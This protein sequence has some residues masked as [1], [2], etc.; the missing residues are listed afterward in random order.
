MSEIDALLKE[1]RRFPPN[2]QWRRTAQVT[3]AGI[4]QRAAADPEKFWAGFA[5]ELEWVQPWSRIL[6][7][8]APHAK[9]FVDG[10]LNA[11]VNCID[12]HLAK[13]ANQTAIWRPRLRR[14]RSKRRPHRSHRLNPSSAIRSARTF[15]SPT[16]TRR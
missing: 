11:S 4:Y 10:K 13:R 2:D 12:R 7:W 8:K 1:D 6:E 15:T 5:R 3:D 9:W 14:R 16:T